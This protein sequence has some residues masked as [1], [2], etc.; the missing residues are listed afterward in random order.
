MEICDGCAIRRMSIDSN[1]WEHFFE[2]LSVKLWLEA[3]SPEHTD[4]E[5]DTIA[6]LLGAA[7]GAELLDVPCGGGR[8]SLAL[9][10]RGYRLT[11]VDVSRRVPRSRTILRRRQIA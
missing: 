6:R 7:P 8:L 2:G 5:A 4:N 11:G 1:W 3:V 9:A 10:E